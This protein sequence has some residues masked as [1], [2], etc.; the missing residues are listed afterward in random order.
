MEEYVEE[1]EAS[2]SELQ[3][4]QAIDPDPGYNEQ[5]DEAWSQLGIVAG[6]VLL[7]AGAL[8]FVRKRFS[9]G[10]LPGPIQEVRSFHPL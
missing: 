1:P 9:R 10:Q 4:Y 2:D 5:P 3:T 6:A 7:L 8:F